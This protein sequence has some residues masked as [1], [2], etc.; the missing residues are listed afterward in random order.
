MEDYRYFTVVP[1]NFN[2]EDVLAKNQINLAENK[3]LKKIIILTGICILIASI[4][5]V[6]EEMNKK[7]AVFKAASF[8]IL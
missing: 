6:N 4:Y 7:L 8:Q 1:D 2:Y 5:L 3:K